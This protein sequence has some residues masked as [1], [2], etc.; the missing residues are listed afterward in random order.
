MVAGIVGVSCI[1]LSRVTGPW[2]LGG[3][4]LVALSIAVSDA[5][6]RGE[7][8][9]RQAGLF[10][11]TLAGALAAWA[12]A[13]VALLALFDL[14]VESWLLVLLA[15]SVADAIAGALL[16]RRREAPSARSQPAVRASDERRR[17]A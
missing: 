17:A 2:A 8:G 13:V 4:V 5:L 15:G 6:R 7:L 14:P 1:V 11:V 16:M 12:L 3:S 10:M 9:L